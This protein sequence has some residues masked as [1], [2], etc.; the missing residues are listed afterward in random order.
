[1]TQPNDDATFMDWAEYMKISA[2][3]SVLSPPIS[4]TE[5][6]ALSHATTGSAVLNLFFKVLRTSTAEQIATLMAESW[7]ENPLLTLRAIFHLRDCRG[8][9]GE[10]KAFYE[11]LRWLITNGQEEQVL[12][13]LENIPFFGT[14][15]D[16]LIVCG[17]NN[18]E[19]PMLR[20]YATTLRDDLDT[21]NKSVTNIT[22]VSNFDKKTISTTV[23]S[24]TNTTLA[25]KWAP[26]EGGEMDKKFNYVRKLTGLLRTSCKPQT[27][28]VKNARD[29]RK[30]VT[31]P[32]RQHANIVET[33]MCANS[34]DTIDYQHVPSM[35]M[36]LYR[37]AF[38]KHSD[39]KFAKY[40]A[41]VK[42]GKKTINASAVFPH[43]LVKH[44]MNGGAYDETIELQWK[45]LVNDARAA[46]DGINAL[47]LI[48]VSH[49]M[50]GEPMQV[51]IALGLLLSEIAPDNFRGAML[52]F[53]S[54]PELYRVDTNKS[55]KDKVAIIRTLPWGQ[56]T[57]IAK[58]FDLILD[59][60][61]KGNVQE[62]AMPRTLYIFSDMQFDE[63]SPH[64][65]QTNFQYIEENYTRCGYR[66]P[67][68]VFWNLRGNTADFPVEQHVP[69]CALVSGFSPSL[70]KLFM[71]GETLS[72]YATMLSA[73]TSPRYARVKLADVTY[74]EGW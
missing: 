66:R 19:L 69:N 13:N 71:N 18:L 29:Y 39:E 74:P 10:K 7:K 57:N 42:C 54:T 33:Q 67:S 12:S 48:D 45:A 62:A 64:N 36:K 17:G 47:P 56:S 22:N 28:T 65:S 40:L 49:S 70:L 72:P 1:M 11:C 20:L 3:N 8:G 9:K 51:A 6:G 73:L 32:L 53:T 31:V 37:K 44:Y 26:T 23:Q 16:L 35:A 25:G 14:Y 43:Q 21:L 50:H 61:V 27:V 24:T 60:A 30:L 52:T 2:Q 63:A 68:I 34:W 55:L 15:K 58:A 46:G 38:A 59:T 4:Q 41:D 5:N